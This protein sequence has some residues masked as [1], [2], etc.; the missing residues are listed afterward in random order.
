[1][2]HHQA[3]VQHGF[4]FLKPL[5]YAAMR[6]LVHMYHKLE[7]QA[8]VPKQWLVALVALLSKSAEIETPIALV[9]TMYRLWCRLR[10]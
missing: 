6:D 8:T 4:D 7:E 3:A 1:M 10:N 2:V 5:P 9:A